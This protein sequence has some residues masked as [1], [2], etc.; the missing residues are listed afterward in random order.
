MPTTQTVPSRLLD[1]IKD[2]I[3]NG[4]FNGLV[5]FIG[6]YLNLQGLGDPASLSDQDILILTDIFLSTLIN[7]TDSLILSWNQVSPFA[8]R[9]DDTLK[10]KV[11]HLT[12][13]LFYIIDLKFNEITQMN[14]TSINNDLN[15]LLESVIASLI[16]DLGKSLN[17]PQD[18]QVNQL[19]SQI[20]VGLLCGTNV[21]EAL[22]SI[23][24]LFE[25]FL[26]SLFGSTSGSKR[27]IHHM[28]VKRSEKK[29]VNKL[30][31]NLGTLADIISSL[32]NQSIKESF[33]SSSN[34]QT[35]FNLKI[36]NLAS[37]LDRSLGKSD[38]KRTSLLRD[39][40]KKN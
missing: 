22:T 16:T 19:V 18:D 37:V 33:P 29:S 25:G 3:L 31:Y 14:S 34:N 2:S 12:E 20:I 26:S 17:I 11:S 32:I 4:F 30:D 38:K 23:T 8:N 9:Q 28:I 5:N 10:D 27:N 1:S 36:S 13:N 6:Y 24:N 39:L 15:S 7:E 21:N 35:E 40:F